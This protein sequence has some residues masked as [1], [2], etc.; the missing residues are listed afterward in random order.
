[1]HHPVHGTLSIN[2]SNDG[3]YRCELDYDATKTFTL[4][5]VEWMRLIVR[6]GDEVLLRKI[7]M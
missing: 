4:D 5:S 2:A 3:E 7:E 6:K 1:M